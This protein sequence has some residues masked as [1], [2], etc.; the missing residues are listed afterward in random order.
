MDTKFASSLATNL[1]KENIEEFITLLLFFEK[2]YKELSTM[3][4]DDIFIN[5]E[6]KDICEYLLENRLDVLDIDYILSKLE[7]VGIESEDL[8][9]EN[10]KLDLLYEYT[11]D[12]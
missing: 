10:W 8:N 4:Y 11:N 6:N 12:E 7:P 9:V 3:I 5:S 1:S 2:N